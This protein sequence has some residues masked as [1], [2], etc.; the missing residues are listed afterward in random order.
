MGSSWTDRWPSRVITWRSSAHKSS[1]WGGRLDF[2]EENGKASTSREQA[3]V[4]LGQHPLRTGSEI[5]LS[6]E[7]MERNSSGAFGASGTSDPHAILSSCSLHITHVEAR[8]APGRPGVSHE[9]VYLGSFPDHSSLP[10]EA[11]DVPN[12]LLGEAW[13]SPSLK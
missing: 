9:Y 4:T 5:K 1:G 11:Y 3:G 6:G 12:T 10:T 2:R 7:Q 8:L 13:S